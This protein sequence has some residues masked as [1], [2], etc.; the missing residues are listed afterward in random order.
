MLARFKRWATDRFAFGP[1][2][3]NVLRRRVPASPWYFGDGAT[4]TLLLMVLVATGALM[5]MTYSADIGSA[6]DSVV[7][8]THVQVL[9]WFIR[10][11]HYWAAGLMVVMLVFHFLRQILLAGYKAPREGTWLIGVLLF[12]AVIFMAYSG[13]LLRWDER[14]ITAIKV[15]MH[16]FH[17]VPWIGDDLVV[18]VQGGREIGPLTLTRIHGLHAIIV[19][20]LIFALTG[21]HLYLVIQHGTTAPTEKVVDV[22]DAEHQREIYE[23]DAESKKR[24]EYFYPYT[25]YHSSIFA[26]TVLAMVIGLS[27][28]VGPA[29]LMGPATLYA[30]S[31]PMEEWWFW[32]YSSLIA[33]LPGSIAPSFVVLFPLMLFIGMVLLPFLDRGPKRGMS[34]RPWAV[35]FVVVTVIVLLVLSSMRMQS[36]W[37]AWPKMEPPPVPAGVVLSEDTERGRQL[38]SSYGCN[39]CHAVAGHGR[40]VAVDLAEVRRMAHAE[41]VEYIRRPPPGIAMPAYADIPEEDLTR[42]AEYVLAAQTFP[43]EAE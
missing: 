3:T 8:I 11:V 17:N 9:G 15:S 39:S 13:Y 40:Q 38:F 12:F 43:R 35:A 19:P 32:W 16:M 14:A 10:A 6:Y 37:T 23:Y 1:I 34:G 31:F 2:W 18:L 29:E 30:R 42:L 4:L 36:P 7:Y 5:S 28:I 20:L 33:L 41:L 22:E 27:L 24:G 26:F 21:Y 25:L